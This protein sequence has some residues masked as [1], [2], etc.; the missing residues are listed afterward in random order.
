MTYQPAALTEVSDTEWEALASRRIFFGHQSVGRDIMLG[1]RQV[2]AANPAI[3]LK[4]VDSQDP[5]AVEGPAFVEARIG[6]NREPVTKSA[7]FAAVLRS[8]YGAEPGA[9]A[10]YK[11][12]YV[13]MQP[14]SDPVAM[15]D[16]YAERIEALRAEFPDLTIVHFTVPLRTA[17]SGMRERVMTRLGRPTETALNVKRERYNQLIREHYGA[18]DPLFDLARIESTR[19]DGTPA[20]SIHGGEAV[21][22]LAPEWSSDGG[23]LNET[24]QRHTAEQLLVFLARLADRSAVP[25]QAGAS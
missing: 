23:H 11:F 9:V 8:G 4:V 5:A 6:R 18:R 14:G 16:E 12:C 10:M 2:L 19:P 21:P 20:Y 15:F 7:A 3:A 25:M 13:D 24:G 1:V 22:M 17:P